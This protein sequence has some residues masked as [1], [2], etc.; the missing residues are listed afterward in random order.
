LT[1]FKLS[2]SRKNNEPDL[3]EHPLVKQIASSHEKSPAQVLLRHLTQQGIIVI[4]KSANPI[5]I[6]ENGQVPKFM[7]L[8]FNLLAYRLSYISKK[9]KQS[10]WK[11]I[12]MISTFHI[13]FCFHPV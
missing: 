6:K 5:R 10:F 2:A 4:P 12:K 1:Y 11:I 7:L 8:L 13:T 9:Q 3:L